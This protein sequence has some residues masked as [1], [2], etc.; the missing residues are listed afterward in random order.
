[1]APVP[2]VARQVASLANAFPAPLT[3]SHFQAP[4]TCTA[5]APTV[6]T[7]EMWHNGSCWRARKKMWV[8]GGQGVCTLHIHMSKCAHTHSYLLYTYCEMCIRVYAHVHTWHTYTHIQCTHIVKWAHLGVHTHT[9]HTQIH[10][11]HTH[12]YLVSTYCEMCTSRC[13]HTHTHGTWAYIHTHTQC[14]RIV[15]YAHRG[16]CTHMAHTHRGTH[17]HMHT[18]TRCT[19][20]VRCAHLDVCTHTHRMQTHMC[21]I[22]TD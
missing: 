15:R 8:Q 12:S 20:I 19:Y 4:A 18:H 17:A 13:R 1:M 6:I 7:P 21:L 16:V 3:P 22:Q 10:G 9:R 11:I 5:T 14:T 2:K